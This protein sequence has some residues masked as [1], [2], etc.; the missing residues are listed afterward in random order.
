MR[1][2]LA[3]MTTA[4][5]YGTWL[6]GDTRGYVEDGQVLPGDPE[7][8]ER[9]HEQM[10]GT[11]VLLTQREQGTE[12]TA[13]TAATS[14]FSYRL[15]ARKN[16]QPVTAADHRELRDGSLDQAVRRRP[17][18]HR[19]PRPSSA[20]EAGSG[21]A[22]RPTISTGSMLPSPVR[23]IELTEAPSAISKVLRSTS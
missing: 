18:R 13:L 8:W 9:A 3:T 16:R 23:V 6:P 14:E 2:L 1:R 19:P 15:K 10:L 11:L 22:G 4:T 21:M 20:T 12:L 7:G 5:T 17:S